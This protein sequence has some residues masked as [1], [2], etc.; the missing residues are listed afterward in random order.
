MTC[1]VALFVYFTV[2]YTCILLLT[3]LEILR[4]T[5]EVRDSQSWD[6]LKRGT[7]KKETDGLLAATLRTNYIRNKI[8]RQDVLPMCRL[9]GEREETV[10][11]ITTECKK[12]AQ[13]QYK[14]WMHDKVAQAIHW[15]LCK[16]FKLQCKGTWYD[17]S[18]EA[19]ME[20][21]QVKL[22]WDFRIQTDRHLD[23]NRPD[24]VVLEKGGRVCTIIYV[25]CPFDTHI[26][27]KNRRRL[28]PI[29]T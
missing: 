21:D 1:T 5:E 12:L 8:D 2:F 29:R 18:P 16:T 28:T 24:I 19:V 17:H 11:L 6:W 20:N 14:S 15:N 9:C 26:E 4:G 10:S 25:A 13:N 23:H 3:F 27:I 7:L 22:L